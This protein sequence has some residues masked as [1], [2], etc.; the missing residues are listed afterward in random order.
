M[1]LVIICNTVWNLEY[2]TFQIK[3]ITEFKAQSLIFT[4][5]VPAVSITTSQ[6]SIDM[7]MAGQ[8]GI[9]VNPGNP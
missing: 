4:I 8:F 7:T 1:I 2:D 3:Q 9:N 6:Y 5:Y